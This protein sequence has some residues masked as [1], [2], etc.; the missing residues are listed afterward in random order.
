SHPRFF[1]T[2]ASG[3][4]QFLANTPVT[5]RLT[6]AGLERGPRRLKI[7]LVPSSTRVGPTYFI[8]A[9]WAGANMKPRPASLMQRVTSSGLRSILTPNAVK[10]SA[11]PDLD[12]SARLPCFATLSP[13]PAAMKAAQVEIL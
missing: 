7:V 11:A 9:W 4:T 5:C 6:P 10:T 1:S 2:W 8:D 13:A 3:S 12:D